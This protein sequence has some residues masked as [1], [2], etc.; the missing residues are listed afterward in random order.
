MNTAIR[1]AANQARQRPVK[2][3]HNQEVS[4]LLCVCTKFGALWLKR[5]GKWVSYY[6][7]VAE[8]MSDVGRRLE[9]LLLYSKLLGLLLSL[10]KC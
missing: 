9:G 2:L 4:R 6:L 1:E 3:T 10:L 7:K 5:Q 8:R